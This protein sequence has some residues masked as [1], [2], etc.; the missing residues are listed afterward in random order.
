MIAFFV[1]FLLLLQKPQIPYRL[2]RPYS[3][4]CALGCTCAQADSGQCCK[5]SHVFSWVGTLGQLVF[6]CL[7]SVH[8]FLSQIQGHG[9]ISKKPD[10]KTRHSCS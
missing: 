8:V 5:P 10:T 6:V 7:F 4:K 2:A 3:K 1:C 9:I